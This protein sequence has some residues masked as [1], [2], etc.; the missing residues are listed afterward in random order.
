MDID[1]IDS[2]CAF[3]PSDKHGEFAVDGIFLENMLAKGLQV[4]SYTY[5][6]SSRVIHSRRKLDFGR[7]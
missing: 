2:E 5:L 6:I 3:L 1:T 7:V 4:W